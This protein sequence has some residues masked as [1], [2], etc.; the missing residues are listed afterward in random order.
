MKESKLS[1]PK[2]SET[3]LSETERNKKSQP[4]DKHHTEQITQQSTKERSVCPRQ[5]LPPSGSLAP[6]VTGAGKGNE[7]QQN[8]NLVREQQTAAMQNEGADP[9][10]AA[11]GLLQKS[12]VRGIDGKAQCGFNATAPVVTRTMPLHGSEAIY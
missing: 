5:H 12:D 11:C 6:L 4:I 10:Y 7:G 1:D 9:T 8:Q 3:A 2:T